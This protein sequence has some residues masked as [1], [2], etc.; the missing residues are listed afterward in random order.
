[1]T[2]PS[3]DPAAPSVADQVSRLYDLI[4][5]Y[6]L[7]NLIEVAREVGA[8]EAITARPGIDSATLAASLGTDP[9]Y[10]DVLCRTAFAFGLLDRA[11]DGV[12]WRM[13]AHM[14]AILGD[15][16][17]R[18]YL[19]RAARVHLMIGGE[20]Y[21]ELAE[22]LRTGRILPYQ[23]H[24]EALIEEIGEGLS[25][26]PRMFVDLVLPHLPSLGARMTAGARVLDLGCGAGFAMV[27]LARRFP[28]SRVDGVDIEPRSIE[29]ARERIAREDLADRCSAWL[30][31]P[32]GL[33]AEAT[34]DVITMFL[35][36]HEIGP[37]IKDTVLA[38]AARALAPG[39]SLVLFDEAYPETDRGVAHDAHPLLGRR[40]VVRAD[41]GQP[42]RHGHR[43]ARQ[44]RAGRAHG[45][46]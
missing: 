24:S 37:E 28:A 1:M 30:I 21:P 4:A 29:L 34:Y 3:V 2:T 6:H 16:D 27:E 33:T 14:D 18:F 9:G 13:A 31:G 43:A 15:P 41:L 10:T 23:D 20:D 39:G 44:V 19:G 26:L 38:A 11:G 5:G 12:G 40:P 36:V 32:E 17:S 25:S 42:D 46:R 7:T 22:R 45:G 8:W 35:V